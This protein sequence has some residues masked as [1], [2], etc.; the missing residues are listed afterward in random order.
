MNIVIGVNCCW[1]WKVTMKV[2][3]FKRQYT[4]KTPSDGKIWY[5][6]WIGLFGQSSM[7]PPSPSLS[8]KTIFRV[9]LSFLPNVSSSAVKLLPF[10]IKCEQ[11]LFAL[12]IV[13]LR[14]T[15]CRWD[16][17]YSSKTKGRKTKVCALRLFTVTMARHFCLYHLIIP[18]F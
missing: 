1:M 14:L 8:H 7:K 16:C 18:F 15:I 5:R 4:L 13:L 9:L 10:F 12:V 11:K 3:I 2:T 17:R 6:G